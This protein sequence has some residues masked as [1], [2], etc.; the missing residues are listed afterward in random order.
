[1][2]TF[3]VITKQFLNILIQLALLEVLIILEW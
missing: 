3:S 2:N 1:M